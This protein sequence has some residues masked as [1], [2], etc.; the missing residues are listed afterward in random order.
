[1]SELNFDLLKRLCETPGIPGHE[2]RMRALVVDE[3]KPLTDTIE[4][5]VMG[6]VIGFKKG[7]TDGPR[8]MIAAHVDEI[9]FMVK[10]LDER[11]FLRLL[12]VGGWDARVMVAQRVLVH[13]FAGQTLRGTLMPAAKPIHLLT[14]EERNKPPKIEEF[15]VDLG[16]PGDRVKALVEL[17]DMV[18]MDG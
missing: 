9:G 4:A 5:D 2:E 11:G 14:D 12:P 17:G 13:G 1:M 15:Y 16:L 7:A 3:L 8:V 10:H 6:N 18:T